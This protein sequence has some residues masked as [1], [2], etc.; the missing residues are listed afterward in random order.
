[1]RVSGDEERLEVP[2]VAG[3]AAAEDREFTG[4]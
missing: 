4:V 2:R 3:A 1:M